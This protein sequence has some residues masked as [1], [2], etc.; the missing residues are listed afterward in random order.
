MTWAAQPLA[1][2]HRAT[3]TPT[4]PPSL[5]LERRL[6]RLGNRCAMRLWVGV[7]G[8]MLMLWLPLVAGVPL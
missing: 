2:P 4:A 5:W 7:T 3:P 6:R 1:H 8:A